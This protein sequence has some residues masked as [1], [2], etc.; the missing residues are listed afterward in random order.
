MEVSC[1]MMLTQAASLFSTKPLYDKKTLLK[2]Y[3]MKL[4]HK[5]MNLYLYRARFFATVSFG[6]VTYD[7]EYIPETT[8]IFRLAWAQILL[9]KQRSINALRDETHVA[10]IICSSLSRDIGLLS[11]KPDAEAKMENLN[12]NHTS[13]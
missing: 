2:S 8:D 1:G 7:T 10:D 9:A 6:T 13:L 12:A 5:I 11:E 3:L 4:Y